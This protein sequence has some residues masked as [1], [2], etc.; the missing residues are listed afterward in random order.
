MIPRLGKITLPLKALQMN[1]PVFVE[2]M[3]ALQVGFKVLEKVVTAQ[4]LVLIG[5]HASF[6]PMVSKDKSIPSYQVKIEKSE[7]LQCWITTFTEEKNS[8]TTAT[9]L[10]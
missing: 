8:G 5:H 6:R 3:E 7:I 2:Q 10:R 9:Q 4:H 1:D